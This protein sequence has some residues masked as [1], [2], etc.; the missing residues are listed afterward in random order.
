[1]LTAGHCVYDQETGSFAKNWM[2]IPD[3]DEK[4]TYDCPSTEYGCWTA[5]AL[6]AHEGFTSETAFTTQATLHDF[7]VAVVGPGGKTGVPSDL[8]AAVKHSYG[9]RFNADSDLSGAK[10]ARA[11]GYPAAKKY[12]GSVLTYC[13]G[14]TTTD[15]YNGGLTWGL[16]CNMTGGSSGGPWFD[17]SLDLATGTGGAV[18]SLNS[19]GYQGLNYMFGPK[20]N[21]DTSAVYTTALVGKAAAGAVLHALP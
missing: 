6:V 9:L 1:V 11:F 3:F 21:N 20:F 12:N 14:P 7:A 19:Y 15:P 10:V 18:V 17:S 5:T 16:A 8:D 4:P 13:S 2:F